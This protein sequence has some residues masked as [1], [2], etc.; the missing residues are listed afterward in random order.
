MQ[1]F[2][3]KR[4]KYFGGTFDELIKDSKA[5]LASLHWVALNVAEMRLLT[6]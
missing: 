2:S 4:N 3:F 5:I 1:V 6:Y